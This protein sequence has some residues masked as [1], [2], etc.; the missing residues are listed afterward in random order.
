MNFDMF[1]QVSRDSDMNCMFLSDIWFVL[2][3]LV[4]VD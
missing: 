3:P 1:N 4:L 2:G